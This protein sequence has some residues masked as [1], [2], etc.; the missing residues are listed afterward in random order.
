MISTCGHELGFLQQESGLCGIEHSTW[1]LIWIA[2]SLG[3]WKTTMATLNQWFL[4]QTNQRLWHH[5]D[6]GWRIHSKIPH[7]SQ[8]AWFHT[9]YQESPSGPDL[10]QSLCVTM[11]ACYQHIVIQSGSALMKITQTDDHAPS[12]EQ[13]QESQFCSNW[14]WEVMVEGQV[15]VIV[16]AIQDGKA[17]AV[18]DGS[19]KDGQGVAVWT[20]EGHSGQDKITG[21]CLVLGTPDDHS[22][23]CCKFNGDPGDLDDCILYVG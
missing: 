8:T 20:I 9:H 12:W 7:H 22:A 4:T 18:S 2:S 17:L 1:H 19:Y 23:F 6:G 13:F 21:A 11:V 10:E 5:M 16:Q 15:Q 14:K 3:A